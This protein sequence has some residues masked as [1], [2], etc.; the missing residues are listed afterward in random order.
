MILKRTRPIPAE[1]TRPAEPGLIRPP[2]GRG[3]KLPECEIPTSISA[4]MAS[5]PA[6]TGAD[7]LKALNE[8]LLTRSYVT[9]CDFHIVP[10]APAELWLAPMS[11]LY[12]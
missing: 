9:G 11:L 8:H 3:R 6:L 7:G 12:P 5:F 4:A 1:S 10:S 2:A